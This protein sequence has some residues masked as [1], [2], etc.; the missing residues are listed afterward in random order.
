MGKAKKSEP[1][2]ALQIGKGQIVRVKADR[3]GYRRAGVAHTKAG[4]DHPADAF[5]AD[6]MAALQDDPRLTVSVV[7]A[8]DGE[9]AK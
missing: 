7:D 3:D 2:A 4:I 1:K 6:Q 8:T 5:T 9:A